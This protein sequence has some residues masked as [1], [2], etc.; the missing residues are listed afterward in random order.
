VIGGAVLIGVAV[1]IGLGLLANGFPTGPRGGGSGGSEPPAD[2]VTASTGS[3]TTGT[4]VATGAELHT[5][6]LVTVFV[7]NGSG[8]VGVAQEATDILAGQ[9]YATIPPAN[10]TDVPAS[11][12]FYIAEYQ[13]DAAAIAAVL[14]L[15]PTAVE[16]MPT[17]PPV[18][19]LA[20][21]HVV[22]VLGPDYQAG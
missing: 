17:P 11:K 18:A 22:I 13:P 3:D 5:P 1:V 19:D 6:A 2:G 15:P 9:G 4:T 20:G 10:A 8:V 21:A 16:A 7:H 14:G 12:V